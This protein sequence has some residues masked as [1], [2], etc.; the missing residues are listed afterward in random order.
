[1]HWS[2]LYARTSCVLVSPASRCLRTEESSKRESSSC[3]PWVGRPLR[4]WDCSWGRLPLVRLPRLI[5]FH[6]QPSSE[7]C[8]KR[9]DLEINKKP[10]K[11]LLS[12]DTSYLKLSNP[13]IFDTWWSRPLIFN[14]GEFILLLYQRSTSSCK[15]IVIVNCSKNSIPF[16]RHPKRYFRLQDRVKIK[17]IQRLTTTAHCRFVH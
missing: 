14:L 8:N 17:I 7:Y 5:H 9:K 16:Q 1:M 13:I 3:P 4:V 6:S 2:R 10:R 11:S 12:H 15:C